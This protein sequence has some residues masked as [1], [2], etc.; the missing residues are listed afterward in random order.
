[1]IDGTFFPRG[2]PSRPF[3]AICETKCLGW[4]SVLGCSRDS[5]DF[6]LGGSSFDKDCDGDIIAARRF[7]L[8]GLEK[9]SVTLSWPGAGSVCTLERLNAST[10]GMTGEETG[11]PSL[12]V[13]AICAARFEK[14]A[15]SPLRRLPPLR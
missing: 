3:E 9:F 1:M 2:T 11:D 14:G 4:G 5:V 12:S 6:R 15:R 8:P 7:N 13:S 10:P